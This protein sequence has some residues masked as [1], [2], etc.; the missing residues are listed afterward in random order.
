[1]RPRAKSGQNGP[2][3]HG[4]AYCDMGVVPGKEGH[5][6]RRAFGEAMMA[7]ATLAFV[8][9]VLVSF[10]DRVHTEF[11]TR[12]VAHPTEQ[13]ALAGHEASNVTSVIAQA[14]RRQSLDHAP[15]LI[16][17]LAAT[18]LVLFMLRM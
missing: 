6:M 9:F 8:L 7:A 18:V 14:A 13:I 2:F 17:T 16:F 3:P 4:N 10:D 11:S 1:V 12:F 15:L 5:A